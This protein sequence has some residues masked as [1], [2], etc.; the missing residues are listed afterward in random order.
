MLDPLI[1]TDLFA[2]TYM[3]LQR[4]MTGV[5]EAMSLRRPSGLT[6]C[7]NWLVGHLVAT[8]ANVLVGLLG[9]PQSWHLAAYMRYVSEMAPTDDET[10]TALTVHLLHDLERS[11]NQLL[12]VLERLT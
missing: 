4:H 2:E 7:A 12:S 11:Q 10:G 8:R 3:L 1:F 9:E 5:N 6:L